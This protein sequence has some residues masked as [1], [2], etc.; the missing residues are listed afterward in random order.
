MIWEVYTGNKPSP[1]RAF[2]V[3]PDWP[4]AQLLQGFGTA[5]HDGALAGEKGR[6]CT[7]VELKY[8]LAVLC[9]AAEPRRWPPESNTLTVGGDTCDEMLRDLGQLNKSMLATTE[10]EA[11]TED[12]VKQL[13]SLREI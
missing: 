5:Q 6:R 13:V 9:S 10:P 2:A 12:L 4:V 1:F 11:A 8:E 7:A 3:E